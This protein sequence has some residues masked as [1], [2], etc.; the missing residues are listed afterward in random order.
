MSSDPKNVFVKFVI[1][2]DKYGYKKSLFPRYCQ[3]FPWVTYSQTTKSAGRLIKDMDSSFIGNFYYLGSVW[4]ACCWRLM[5][6]V[7]LLAVLLVFHYYLS[8]PQA[9]PQY[10]SNMN[11]W[12]YTA[13]LADEMLIGSLNFE[14]S[15]LV[16][17]PRLKS[18][19]CLTT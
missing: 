7:I 1:S 18:P 4:F 5:T 15:W 10:L 8:F 11:N 3:P 19:V 13:T 16:V 2:A 14:L 9:F 6:W 17:L 12:P